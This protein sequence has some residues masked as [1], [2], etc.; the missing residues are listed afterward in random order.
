MSILNA[1]QRPAHPPA[2]NSQTD[3][4]VN[5]EPNST[6][7]DDQSGIRGPNPLDWAKLL[8]ASCFTAFSG[9]AAFSVFWSSSSTESDCE[10]ALTLAAD[11]SRQ[12]HVTREQELHR[13]TQLWMRSPHCVDLTHGYGQG[14]N[15]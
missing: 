6:Q 2:A 10:P 7:V 1:G 9:F 5:S 3:P 12:A 14:G 8:L 13:L 11:D 4:T 15:C